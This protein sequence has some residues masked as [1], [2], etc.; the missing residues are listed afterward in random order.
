MELGRAAP[1]ASGCGGAARQVECARFPCRSCIQGS[2]S[3]AQRG[4]GRSRPCSRVPGRARR[5][6]RRSGGRGRAGAG[7]PAPAG[8]GDTRRAAVKGILSR[9]QGDLGAQRCAPL[10]TAPGAPRRTELYPPGDARRDPAPSRFG[11][12]AV[13]RDRAPGPAKQQIFA[14]HPAHL[15]DCSEVHGAEVVHQGGRAAGQ[16]LSQLH[17]PGGRQQRSESGG[18]AAAQRARAGGSSAACQGGRQQLAEGISG[19]YRLRGASRGRQGAAQ[20]GR[21]CKRP[22]AAGCAHPCRPSARPS[23]A[24]AAGCSARRPAGRASRPGTAPRER[25]AAPRPRAPP[26]PQ[27]QARLG[28]GPPP[29]AAQRPCSAAACGWVGGWVGRRARAWARGLRAVPLAGPQRR[30]CRWRHWRRLGAAVSHSD[31]AQVAQGPHG[32][33]LHSSG[34]GQLQPQRVEPRRQ[35]GRL[36]AARSSAGAPAAHLQT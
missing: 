6:S 1:G 5:R 34:R 9:C 15:Q 16:P 28:G 12:R 11:S 3:P 2:G 32:H 27:R 31:N 19:G 8:S 20:A 35:P 24:P 10:L 13:G 23:R 18:A 36:Q 7:L 25:Q 17:L 26:V 33:P 29:R 30:C 21:G 22:A 14:P 4:G